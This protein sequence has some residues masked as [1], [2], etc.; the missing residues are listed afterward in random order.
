MAEID[1]KELI[2]K[3]K[4]TNV[5]IS[6]DGKYISYI[7]NK[8][9]ISKLFIMDL[10]GNNIELLF[11]S[12]NLNRYC[13]LDELHIGILDDNNGNEFYNLIIINIL[14]LEIDKIADIGDINLL[15][16]GR[17]INGNIYLSVT[18]DSEFPDVYSY[19]L[20]DKEIEISMTNPGFIS[21]WFIDNIGEIRLG[22]IS[23]EDGGIDLVNIVD[24]Y[25][26]I[27]SWDV[28]DIFS[29]DFISFSKDNNSIYVKDSRYTNTSSILKIDLNNLKEDNLFNNIKYDIENILINPNTFEI[30]GISVF[31][32]RRKYYYTN[33]D[34]HKIIDKF[35]LFEEDITIISRDIKNNYMILLFES[36]IKKRNYY[37][38]DLEENI[39]KEIFK[40][41]ISIGEEKLSPMKSIKYKSRDDLE[42]H[43]YITIPITEK[44]SYPLI[45][46]VHGGP[47]SRD[48]WGYNPINQWLSSLGYMI[49]QINFRGSIGYGKE[50][51]RLGYKE[52]GG[53]MLEDII[54]GVL[55]SIDNYPID[56]DKICIY[57][58]SYGGYA[59]LSALTSEENIFS[60][61]ISINGPTN[62]LSFLDNMPTFWKNYKECF[63]N[64]IGHPSLDKELLINRSPINHVEKI[65][66][67]L[68]I[69]QGAMDSR[70]KK[71]ESEAIVNKMND[72]GIDYKYLLF[73]D[74]GHGI[75]KNKNRIKLYKEIEVFLEKYL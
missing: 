52:W 37:I 46:N 25:S 9:E 53:K 60:C 30:E 6:P 31:K 10:N 61:G 2:E 71:N 68:L 14:N 54:D 4:Y 44:E 74:E 19:N 67:P 72:K 34:F 3:E 58:G 23:R 1:I 42:I 70:V 16:S 75:I 12:V 45:V 66:V 55:Y 48:Y 26:K 73:Q 40:D 36:D 57:G 59:V 39:I 69:V 29:S 27:L 41:N 17:N 8:N 50:F 13:W 20:L 51:I 62:L 32:E 38:Y 15:Y 5:K 56:K 35:N 22:Y 28:D 11:E 49:L 43:G 65:K 7:E 47:Q 18:K 24:D 64:R 33:N 21:D 63:Y